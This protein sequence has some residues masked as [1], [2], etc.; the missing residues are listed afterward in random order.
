[1]ASVQFIYSPFLVAA[2]PKAGI[3][4][5]SRSWTAQRQVVQWVTPNNYDVLTGR[6]GGC[7]KCGLVDST[8]FMASSAEIVFAVFLLRPF[9]K[10]VCVSPS[11]VTV[12]SHPNSV[13]EAATSM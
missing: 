12:H 4:A 3:N 9:P 7:N 13:M 2:E 11:N 10:N 5:G 1:M 6:G 8:Y